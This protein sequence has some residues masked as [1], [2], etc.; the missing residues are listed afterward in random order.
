M[1][2]GTSHLIDDSSRF[3][4]DGIQDP[5]PNGRLQYSPHKGF[6]DADNFSLAKPAP[7]YSTHC[8]HYLSDSGEATFLQTEIRPGFEV[9][10]TKALFNEEMVISSVL[11]HPLSLTFGFCISGCSVSRFNYLNEE[12]E[13]QEGHQGIVYTPCYSSISQLRTGA[14]LLQVGIRL[15]AVQLGRVFDSE[16]QLLPPILQHILDHM[17]GENFL[18][19]GDIT[20]E[21][22]KAVQ[23]IVNC[24]PGGP[25]R[26]LFL[27]SKALELISY[28][29]ESFDT[30][31]S[32]GERSRAI[33]PEDWRRTEHARALLVSNIANPPSLKG[34]AKAVGMSHPKL[35]DC[36]R[37]VYGS[38]VFEYLRN[39]RL[40]R[41]RAMLKHPKITVTEVAYALGYS[42]PSHFSQAYKKHYGRLPRINPKRSGLI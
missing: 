37:Q 16:R 17:P 21:M 2:L 34:L 38:T 28:Q 25:A 39:E 29:L 35:N 7:D 12:M 1:P 6:T 31:D 10:V 30:Q 9:S 13:F 8:W 24:R 5:L 40:L 22:I 33:H 4:E 15:E 23:E 18:Q 3:A 14:P 27:E 11:D 26:K 19:W 32:S 41:A 36:F 20:P 42:S